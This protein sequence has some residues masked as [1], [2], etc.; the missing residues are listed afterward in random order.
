MENILLAVAIIGAVIIVATVARRRSRATT[1]Q[2]ATHSGAYFGPAEVEAYV[3]EHATE[4]G[5]DQFPDNPD[6]EWMVHGFTHTEKL[7]LAEVEPQPPEVGYP[8]FKFGFVSGGAT[9]PK[10]MA[11][12]CLDAGS[13]QLLC[14]A[15]GA[16]ANLPPRLD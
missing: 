10:H 16:P 2:A 5:R 13:Y 15:P 3:R 1:T 6:V 14:T 8:R 4:F 7:I 11:T 12:Y 9:P